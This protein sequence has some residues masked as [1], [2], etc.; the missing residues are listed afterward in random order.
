[1]CLRP[2]GDACVLGVPV[3]LRNFGLILPPKRSPHAGVSWRPR[4]ATG[5]AGFLLLLALIAPGALRVPSRGRS[6]QRAR[7][8]LTARALKR[9][10]HSTWG[11]DLREAPL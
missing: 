5:G 6:M 2:C 8:R 9:A 4:H 3:T 10:P 7:G 1:M 11:F